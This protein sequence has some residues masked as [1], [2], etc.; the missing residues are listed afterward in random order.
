MEKD[1]EEAEGDN[2]ELTDENE[3]LKKNI[4]DLAQQKQD[5]LGNSQNIFDL[6]QEKRRS[7]TR[8]EIKGCF[9]YKLERTLYHLLK[10]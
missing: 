2:K 4:E 5:I 8:R 10:Y 3:E 1:I 7:W 9:Q 6:I